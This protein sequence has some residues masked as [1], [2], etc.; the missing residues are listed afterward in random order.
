MLLMFLNSVM[1]SWLFVL[2]VS[3]GIGLLITRKIGS[4]LPLRILVV[5]SVFNLAGIS[6][7]AFMLL[8]PMH[9]EAQVY[10]TAE[11]AA[12]LIT[13]LL[14][15]LPSTVLFWFVRLMKKRELP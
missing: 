12:V 14:C 5:L 1:M 10:A 4:R 7:V 2:V 9:S 11:I 6:A 15:M 13:V 8:M 3:S